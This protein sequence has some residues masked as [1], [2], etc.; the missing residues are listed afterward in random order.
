MKTLIKYRI[1]Q[2]KGSLGK[3][4]KVFQPL[5]V[6][7]QPRLGAAAVYPLLNTISSDDASVETKHEPLIGGKKAQLICPVLFPSLLTRVSLKSSD[8]HLLQF[9]SIS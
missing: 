1:N 7:P 6:D 8:I 4:L 5:K 3:R 9:I 2:R